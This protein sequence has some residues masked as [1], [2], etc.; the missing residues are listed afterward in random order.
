[1]GRPGPGHVG[2][3]VPP[4]T[5]CQE[6]TAWGY[7]EGGEIPARASHLSL[8][9]TLG[10]C[11]WEKGCSLVKQSSSRQEGWQGASVAAGLVSHP[12]SGLERVPG[13]SVA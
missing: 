12:L 8:A 7:W 11:S 9:L 4:P 10:K 2:A 3:W 1:M 13:E 5:G 6:C